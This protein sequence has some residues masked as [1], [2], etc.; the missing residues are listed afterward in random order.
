[1]KLNLSSGEINHAESVAAFLEVLGCSD[2]EASFYLESALWDIQNAVVL[3]LENNPHPAT[4]FAHFGPDFHSPSLATSSSILTNQPMPQISKQPFRWK[5]RTVEIIGLDPTWI[6]KVNPYDG[7][8]YFVSRLTGLKQRAV[9]PGFADNINNSKDHYH[10]QTDNDIVEID[11][12]E[13][14]QTQQ[15]S[16]NRQY[17]YDQFMEMNT[18]NMGSMSNP[19]YTMSLGVAVLPPV[20]N[21]NYPP[22]QQQQ[23]PSHS[24]GLYH[25]FGTDSE[26]FRQS[27]VQSSVQQSFYPAH[28][29]SSSSFQQQQQRQQ[30]EQQQA[31][32]VS[33]AEMAQEDDGEEDL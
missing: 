5:E 3:W 19:Q 9:P 22:S 14:P 31:S 1:M 27:L 17:S 7:S 4:S 10:H 23:H 25:A 8:I 32:F 16:S 2:I 13:D 29:S 11:D 21:S 28:S 15:S 24:T 6:A 18:G 12:D 30:Q 20:N 26:Y 33:S